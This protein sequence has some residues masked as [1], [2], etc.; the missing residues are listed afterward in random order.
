MFK[1]CP[2]TKNDP[3]AVRYE[4]RLAGHLSGQWGDWF[5]GMTVT[6]ADNGDT[7]LTGIV[8]DQAAL[9]GLLKR[10][11]DLGMTLYSVNRLET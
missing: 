11:R 8:R 7:V 10:S 4:I 5:D 9:Y 1:H 2:P 3:D 6:A